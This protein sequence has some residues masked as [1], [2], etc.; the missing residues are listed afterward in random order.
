[1]HFISIGS[2]G[3]MVGAVAHVSPR[4][5]RWQFFIQTELPPATTH[6][7]ARDEWVVGVGGG[8]SG[9]DIP[10]DSAPRI[11]IVCH[12]Q[13]REWD[14]TSLFTRGRT[15]GLYLSS[16]LSPILVFTLFRKKFKIRRNGFLGICI[17]S[18]RITHRKNISLSFGNT[19]STA[20]RS[21]LG[22]TQPPIQWYRGIFPQG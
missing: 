18:K 5:Y 21:A 14:A 2:V 13:G 10:T 6:A 20:S 8:I 1:L 9:N 17:K 3:A 12:P 16:T 22:P 11:S 7:L 4:A 15:S 19:Y